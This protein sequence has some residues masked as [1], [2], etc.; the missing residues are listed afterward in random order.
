MTS[1]EIVKAMKAKTPV[2]ARGIEYK[3]IHE[4]V[5]T[6]DDAGRQRRSAGLIDKNDNCL[7]RVLIEDVKPI[8]SP[9]A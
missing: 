2:M 9:S 4:Y 3:Y 5:L 6:F 1:E 8:P 7:V